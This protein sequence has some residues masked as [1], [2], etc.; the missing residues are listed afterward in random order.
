MPSST[1]ASPEK[2]Q[3]QSFF[4]AIAGRYDF[5]NSL[6]SFRLDESWRKR[7]ASLLLRGNEKT[8]LDL[9]TGTGKFLKAFFK[10]HSFEK[11]LGVDF[12]ESMLEKARKDLGEKAEFINADFHNL[13]FSEESFDLIVSAFA[14]RSVK[15]IPQFMRSSF[16]ILKPRGRI[17]IL[18]LTRPEN[19]ILR[20]AH[21]IYL[22]IYL[23]LMGRLISGQKEAY[24]FLSQSIQSFQDPSD[25]LH[26]MENAGFKNVYA[27]SL[28]G[29]IATLF[30][31]EKL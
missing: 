23:P 4:D 14:L 21:A 25:T 10:K 27:V 7:S 29:R 22:N 8:I 30:A 2:N 15:D 18:C 13:P 9:G 6:L 16:R 3:I 1:L 11:A 26:M 19:R 24:L 17:G 31:G 12:S 5:L 28:S 20:W